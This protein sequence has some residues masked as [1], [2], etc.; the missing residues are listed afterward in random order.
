MSEPV[1]AP[2]AYPALASV[3]RVAFGLE[4][5]VTG[6]RSTPFL[7]IFSVTSVRLDHGRF[8]RRCR[9]RERHDCS[10]SGGAPRLRG[11]IE[12]AV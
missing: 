1:S 12:M 8:S 7:P 6:A 9:N 5:K 2:V 3:P 4:P 11:P 10:N